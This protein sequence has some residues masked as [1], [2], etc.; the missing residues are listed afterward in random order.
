VTVA[1]LR[2]PAIGAGADLAMSCDYRIGTHRASFQF[3]GA[4]FGV[5]LGADRLIGEIGRHRAVE[6]LLR[7]A[8]V[9]AS[10]A[11]EYGLLTDVVGV[12]EEKV[13]AERLLRD[14]DDLPH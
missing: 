14:I 13:F 2:G 6:I 12:E 4:R 10:E 7:N 11:L 8:K 9:N 3:P 5:M 1:S